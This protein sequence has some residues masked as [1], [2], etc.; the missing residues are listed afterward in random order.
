MLL[1]FLI[2]WIATNSKE[3]NFCVNLTWTGEPFKGQ[4]QGFQ[5]AAN[6]LILDPDK[7]LAI[8]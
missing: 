2:Y 7:Q 5:T 8:L 4:T 6:V 1:G 3:G